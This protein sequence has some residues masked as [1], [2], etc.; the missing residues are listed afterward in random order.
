MQKMRLKTEG[1]RTVDLFEAVGEGGEGTVYR[2]ID[3][4]SGKQ[5]A[6][7]LFREEFNRPENHLRVRYLI[8]KKLADRCPVICVPYDLFT[9]PHF[10]HCA[11]WVAGE[12]LATWLEHEPLTF[13]ES[14][15]I[16]CVMAHAMHVMNSVGISH[17]DIRPENF[18]ALRHR[19]VVEIWMVD[20]DNFVG[21]PDIPGNMLGDGNYLAPELR[22][23]RGTVPAAV[24]SHE[25]DRFAMG[26]LFLE[27]LLRRHPAAGCDNSD[28]EFAKAMCNGWKE[29]RTKDGKDRSDL[30][31]LPIRVLN[32]EVEGLFRRSLDP[33]PARRPAPVSWRDALLS[34]LERL[35]ECPHDGAQFILDSSKTSCPVCR[36]PF[37]DLTLH[38]AGRSISLRS[39]VAV[40]RV[41][42]GGALT[43]SARH[44][45]FHREGPDTRMTPVGSNP[46]YRWAKGNWIKLPNDK[47][48]LI[49]P[50]DRLRFAD[51]E[52]VVS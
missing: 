41:H 15:L 14:L 7:K 42:F 32:P 38:A 22:R 26:V 43:V 11:P 23:G 40:G 24:P 10:G 25:S 31:G 44:A 3:R 47:S 13:Q 12:S 2:G 36:T 51:V 16:A 50:G 17:G 27:I 39:S 33:D 19:G 20:L 1:N 45:L 29:D 6:I 49:C 46:T 37:P 4:S 30:G 35:H 48:V 5:I 9:T 21:P 52:A 8:G 18:M 34:A 28:E